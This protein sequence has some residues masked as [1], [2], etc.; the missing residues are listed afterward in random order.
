MIIYNYINLLEKYKEQEGLF[1]V[2]KDKIGFLR[3]ECYSVVNEQHFKVDKKV[4]K[5]F[6]EHKKC[7]PHLPTL[8][9]LDKFEDFCESVICEQKS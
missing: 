6:D 1:D 5:Y 3:Q 2:C 4:F 7:F 8:D 9:Q